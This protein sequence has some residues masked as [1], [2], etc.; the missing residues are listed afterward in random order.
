M[1]DVPVMALTAT[2]V[3]KVQEDILNSLKMHRNTYRR[4][5]ML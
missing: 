3:P 5:I 1:P 2:A 4:V